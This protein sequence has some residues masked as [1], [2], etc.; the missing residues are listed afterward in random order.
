MEQ[1]YESGNIEELQSSI[2]KCIREKIDPDDDQILA[3]KSR[4]EFLETKK[5]KVN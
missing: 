1:A 5:G 3:S 4:L 2:N